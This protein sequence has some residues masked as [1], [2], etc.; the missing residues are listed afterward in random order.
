MFS[1]GIRFSR[2]RVWRWLSDYMV[3]YPR[4][5]SSSY[6]MPWQPEI[7]HKVSPTDYTRT[8]STNITECNRSAFLLSIAILSTA[9]YPDLVVRTATKRAPWVTQDATE[10]NRQCLRQTESVSQAV[11]RRSLTAEH[12][13][14]AWVNS[15]GICGGRSGIWRQ[16]FIR[17]W[18]YGN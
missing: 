11:T 12:R 13:V 16:P 2:W 15:S 8:P 18:H 6:P 5:Q 7:S 4:R 10:S 1:K 17:T 14:R 9:R 3:Q